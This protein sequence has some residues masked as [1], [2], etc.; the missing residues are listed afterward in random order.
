VTRDE[1]RRRLSDHFPADFDLEDTVTAY[2]YWVCNV[3]RNHDREWE[4]VLE[5]F[6]DFALRDAI[7]ESQA[8]KFITIISFPSSPPPCRVIL[9]I[10]R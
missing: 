2:A 10:N 6:V 1:L 5:E 9:R 7:Q 8:Y 3:L 4:S